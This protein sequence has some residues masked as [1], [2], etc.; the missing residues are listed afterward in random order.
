MR[1]SLNEAHQRIFDRFYHAA[2]HGGCDVAQATGI[3]KERTLRL[4]MRASAAIYTARQA[5]GGDTRD[6]NREQ[7][8]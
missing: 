3:A 4:V 1:G 6:Y 5:M 2:L 7:F 8:D